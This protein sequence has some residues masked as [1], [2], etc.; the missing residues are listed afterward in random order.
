ME[1]LQKDMLQHSDKSAFNAKIF[2]LEQEVETLKQYAVKTEIMEKIIEFL[3]DYAIR[4]AALEHK[5][6]SF[7]E[8][9]GGAV[10]NCVIEAMTVVRGQ[11]ERDREQ[12]GSKPAEVESCVK[13]DVKLS[14][15]D[16]SSSSADD[17]SE[18]EDSD[19]KVAH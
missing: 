7:E 5:L 4:T 1:K 12:A 3:E 2:K 19:E 15:P 11:I 9:F 14:V 17:S 16:N 13:E 8:S 6:K 10:K 18:S